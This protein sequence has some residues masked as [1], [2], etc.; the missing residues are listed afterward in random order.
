METSPP[1][2]ACTRAVLDCP[3]HNVFPL[4]FKWNFLCPNLWGQCS[5]P[6]RLSHRRQHV[7]ACRRRVRVGVRA[8]LMNGM[9]YKHQPSALWQFGV[10]VSRFTFFLDLATPLQKD[11]TGHRLCSSWRAGGR[12]ERE[13]GASR[14]PSLLRQ[15]G[16]PLPSP[17]AAPL[18]TWWMQVLTEGCEGCFCYAGCVCGIWVGRAEVFMKKL[19]KFFLQNVP[20]VHLHWVTF[21]L[22]LDSKIV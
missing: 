7:D 19:F 14:A 6:R 3:P 18:P 17:W 8:C 4:C 13:D 22:V 1:W 2:S 11:I 20:E 10:V 5:V 9:F 16:H 12:S 15:Q 21:L